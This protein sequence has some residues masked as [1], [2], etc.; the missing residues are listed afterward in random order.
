LRYTDYILA[1]RKKEDKMRNLLSILLGLV[2]GASVA[3]VLVAFFAPTSSQTLKANI[4]K[5]WDETMAEA[6]QAA[7]DRRA[8]LEAEL[9]EKQQRRKAS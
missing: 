4:R 7:K 5:G 3:V 6:R 1:G 8:E 9:R 2:L